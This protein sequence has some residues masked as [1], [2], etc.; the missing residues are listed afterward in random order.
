M[1]DKPRTTIES[2]MAGLSKEWLNAT[3]E[4]ILEPDL[5]IVD[6]HHHFWDFPTHRYLLDELLDDTGLA[7]WLPGIAT[8]WFTAKA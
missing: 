8:A 5:P 4:E 1:I 6:P 7:A 2:R 3:Q